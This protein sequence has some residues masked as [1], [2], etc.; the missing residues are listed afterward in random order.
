MVQNLDDI[1]IY[2]DPYISKF[3]LRQT[4]LLLQNTILAFAFTFISGLSK[5]FDITYVVSRAWQKPTN[6]FHP[7]DKNYRTDLV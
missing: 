4:D 3:N 1:K 2:T 5:P 7:L 6:L